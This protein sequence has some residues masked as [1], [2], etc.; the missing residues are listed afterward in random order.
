[1]DDAKLKRLVAELRSSAEG[2]AAC[3]RQ[4]GLD[5]QGAQHG[6]GLS[7]GMAHAADRLQA[8]LDEQKEPDRG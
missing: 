1:V 4:L 7:Q 2:F 5:V 6:I 3:V 8:L